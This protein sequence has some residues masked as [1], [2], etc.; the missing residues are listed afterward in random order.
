[1]TGQS[2]PKKKKR[3]TGNESVAPSVPIEHGIRRGDSIRMQDGEEH[4]ARRRRIA[5]F[6]A[7]RQTADPEAPLPPGFDLPKMKQKA[8]KLKRRL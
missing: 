8:D 4:D 2:K 7:P 6:M 1:M 3:E 5:S